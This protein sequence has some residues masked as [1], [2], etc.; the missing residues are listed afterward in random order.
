MAREGPKK[1]AATDTAAGSTTQRSRT[2]NRSQVPFA[3][4]LVLNQWVLSLF[5][6][7]RFEDLAEHLRNE[8]LEG[9]DES[10]IHHFH[11]ALTA[12]LFNLTQLPKALLL[13]YDQNIVKHTQRLNE[14]RIT[15]GEQP[16]VWKYF[17]YLTL[18]FTEIY[19]DR[20][21]HD[22]KS[23]LAALNAQV[24]AYNSDKPEADQIAPFDESAEAWPQLNKLAYWM[25]TG[26]GKTLLMHANILQ[27]QHALT[28]HGRRRE[29]NRILLL[30]P[31]EGLSQQHLRQFEAAG[32][33]AELFNKDARG[34]FSGQAVEIL[35]VTR[36]RE[37]MGDKTIAIDAF[38]GNNLVLVDEGHRGASGGEE[39]AWMRFRNSLCEKGFSFE[40]SA[41]FGQAVKG[42]PRLTE[43]YAKGTLLDYSYRYFYRDGFG[44]DYQ[45]LNINDGTQQNHLELYLVACLLSFFQ[46]Q[47]LYL[48]RSSNFRPFNIEKPLWIFVG[49]SVTATLATRDASD[50]V[51]I[52]QF[53]GRYVADRSGSIQRIE[54]VVNTGLETASGKNL[55]AGRFAYLN[56]CGLTSAQIFDETLTTLFNAPGGGQLYVENLKGAAGEVAL[57]LGAENEAF[58]VINVGDDTKLVKLCEENGLATGER[59]FS[60]SL[61]NEINKPES[62][63]NLLIGSKKFTEGWS[64]WRVSTMGLMNVG[65]GEG[66]QIIQLFGRGVR[67][68]GYGLCLRR[69]GKTDLPDGIER[70]RYIGVLETLG[71]F[72]IHADYM[73]QFRDFLE[74][75]GLYANDDR[76]EY[77]LPVIRNIGTQK[78]KTIRLKKT[79]G[80][81]RTEFGDAFRRLAPVPSL[82]IPDPSSDPSS[83]YLQKNQVILNWYPKI[84]TLKSRGLAGGDADAPPNETH[85]SAQHVAFLDVDHLY[86][87]LERYKAER[88]WY[89]LN[90]TRPA[91]EA[92]LADQSWYRL[93]IPAEE[94]IGDSFEKVHMWEEIAAALLKTYTERYYTF[95]KREWELPHLEYRDL[96]SDDP[97]F[98][99]VRDSPDAGYYRILIDK[100]QEEIVAK[101]GELKASIQKGELKPWE[102]RGMKAIWF[103]KHLYQ[104]LLYLDSTIVEVSPA[105][106]NKGERQFVEDLKAFHDENPD[107]FITG[108][109]Y[110]L[111]NLSKGRG[112]GFFEAGNFHPDFIL[113]LLTGGE[114]QVI[115]VD[116]K[117]IRNLGPSDAKI[118][119]HETIKEIEQRLAD[120]AVH[121]H[122]FIVSNTPSAVMMMLWNLGKAE[123]RRRH[124]LF[125]EE[126][127]QTYIRDMLQ[128]VLGLDE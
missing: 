5:N 94:L 30:T 99:G 61:F 47:R 67:L 83:E 86:L 110:L 101:L 35:E 72:G 58:G 27:Y 33:E 66:A 70:P 111:R 13:E 8:A 22:P 106:L 85:L 7:K 52:L 57:R 77:L 80:G 65:K 108:E 15:R 63:V 55:F 17:Q 98:L 126:D 59:E 24:A 109:L 92:L 36:L 26:S 4:K 11:H 71:I 60:G 19:L 10:N 73:A 42:L 105:P 122:S 2:N 49:G 29:L 74:E 37:E 124:V 75:E 21:F 107:F 40:Y 79:I 53:F 87:E 118:Q 117:G 1:N 100:S 116:P 50:I 43:L 45:I 41:T 91:I 69:S 114:Q 28:Q 25:A 56:T 54:R 12:Q 14:R 16:I 120:T 97:N 103:G 48:E 38:E 20:Y 121:L 78:L 84:Q 93:Q 44:K 128:E 81:V 113:W 76:V 82:A 104:P 9:L 96:E 102:F 39:G 125:Q 62:T 68:K 18:L 64:S 119:F 112:V 31:N 3:Y 23:L 115:F 32:I 90:L 95:R 46:Q 88:G 89:N 127:K 51:E 123:I 34:L 6:V